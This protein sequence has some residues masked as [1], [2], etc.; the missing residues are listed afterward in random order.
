MHPHDEFAGFLVVN[1]LG[2]LA[3]LRR[4]QGTLGVIGFGLQGNALISPIHQILGRIAGHADD[5]HPTGTGVVI[6]AL[7]LAVPVPGITVTDDATSVGLNVLTVDILPNYTV[8][9]GKVPPYGRFEFIVT[10]WGWIVNDCVGGRRVREIS[11][12]II[13]RIGNL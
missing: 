8:F 9:H 4:M 3:D 7:M 11:L 10:Q 12:G 6:N 1:D 13:D 2:T 5:V